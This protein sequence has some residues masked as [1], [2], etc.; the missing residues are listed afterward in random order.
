MNTSQI[1]LPLSHGKLWFDASDLETQNAPD[2]TTVRTIDVL[3]VDE[4]QCYN[5]AYY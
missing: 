5:S 4:I 2:S 1:A 3:F